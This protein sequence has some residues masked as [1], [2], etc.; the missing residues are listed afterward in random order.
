MSDNPRPGLYEARYQ[1]CIADRPTATPDGTYTVFGRHCETDR[2]IAD[3]PLPDP[4]PGDLLAVRD[5][6]AYTYSMASNYNR[7][8]R[9]AVVLASGG[10]ARVIARREPLEHVVDL[11]VMDPS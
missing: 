1:A 11:D 8:S 6:G 5:T 9:P 4:R 2:L 10:H 3:A 7:F